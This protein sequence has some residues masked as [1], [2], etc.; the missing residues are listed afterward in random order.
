MTRNLFAAAG[1]MLALVAAPALSADA[2]HNTTPYPE[3]MKS[4]FVTGCT[5]D[6]MSKPVCECFI[7]L[8][9]PEWTAEEVRAFN[10]K[11]TANPNLEPPPLVQKI[12]GTCMAKPDTQVMAD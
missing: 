8:L 2:P 7:R 1:L 3:V 6:G 11:L 5:E 4:S 12:V 10:E 9:E